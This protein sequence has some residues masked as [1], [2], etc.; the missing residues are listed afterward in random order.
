MFQ[1]VPSVVNEFLLAI[2]DSHVSVDALP[3]VS[4]EGFEHMEVSGKW[5]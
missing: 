4:D 2:L 3:L 1:V 5:R